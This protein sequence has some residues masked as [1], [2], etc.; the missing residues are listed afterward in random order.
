MG[1]G[2][3]PKSNNAQMI[4]ITTLAAIHIAIM[5]PSV[6]PF[7][8]SER[9]FSGNAGASLQYLS[10]PDIAASVGHGSAGPGWSDLGQQ[11]RAEI[12]R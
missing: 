9:R 4:V 1:A 8:A 10:Q 3:P 2:F 11:A 7:R 5:L 6:V 12:A